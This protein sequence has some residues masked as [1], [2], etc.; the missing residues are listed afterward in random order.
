VLPSQARIPRFSYGSRVPGP[1]RLT[2]RS[3]AVSH[4]TENG[5][6]A[7]NSP[8]AILPIRFSRFLCGIVH[9][10][11]RCVLP[12]CS[13][14]ARPGSAHSNLPTARS[15]HPRGSLRLWTAS[16]REPWQYGR[17][18]AVR[19]PRA[20]APSVSGHKGTRPS[21]LQGGRP[22][23]TW[24]AGVVVASCRPVAAARAAARGRHVRIEN[25]NLIRRLWT[26]PRCECFLSDS[27][28]QQSRYASPG[29]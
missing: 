12:R 13:H 2:E 6:R 11:R 23:G 29:V 21:W 16:L 5:W 28:S 14:Y 24:W 7:G 1:S 3:R 19:I 27:S 20:A 22:H 26:P 8:R 17:H 9:T 15:W 18:A 4:A 25:K 10:C